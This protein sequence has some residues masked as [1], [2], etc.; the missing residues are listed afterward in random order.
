MITT[1][2]IVY[3]KIRVKEKKQV[4][5]TFAEGQ[6]PS[7]PDNEAF[8]DLNTVCPVPMCTLNYFFGHS[9]CAPLP[10]EFIG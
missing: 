3:E 10:S 7:E 9:R 6:A 2:T 5:D 8:F 4:L 1:S